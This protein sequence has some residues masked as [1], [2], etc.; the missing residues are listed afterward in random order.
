MVDSVEVGAEDVGHFHAHGGR[1][2]AGMAAE[3][4]GVQNVFVHDEADVVL[5]VVH[6]AHDADRARFDVEVLLHELGVREG[7]AGD[8][9]LAGDLLRLELFVVLDHQQVELRLLAVA[10][11]Q[12][13]ADDCRRQELVDFRT[14]F[15]RRRG[16]G[17]DTLVLDAEAV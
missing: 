7:Q 15:H 8:A 13:L 2:D 6:E 11:E 1:V 10:Q 12:V 9:Q 3:V 14:D 5:C 17:V 4:F 16:L